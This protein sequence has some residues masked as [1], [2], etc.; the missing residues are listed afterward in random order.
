MAASTHAFA[1][2]LVIFK[3]SRSIEV[4]SVRYENNQCIFTKN[5]SERIVSLDLIEEIYVL[6]K[7]T[8]YPPHQREPAK[9]QETEIINET[10]ETHERNKREKKLEANIA[11]KDT[12]E[13]VEQ[14]YLY[15]SPQGYFQCAIPKSWNHIEMFG[16]HTFSP[17]SLDREAYDKFSVSIIR[18]MEK[19]GI[20][21]LSKEH[22]AK[23]LEALERI[24]EKLLSERERVIDGIET[25]E[26]FVENTRYEP[27]IMHEII[28]IHNGY[29]VSVTLQASPELFDSADRQFEKII[30]SLDFL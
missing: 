8:I 13:P 21:T 12:E 26:K 15:K 18:S 2:T 25:W 14:I 1:Q 17:Y 10:K 5:G 27:K 3:D 20:T 30:E 23:M 16:V 22:R 29:L 6:N 11:S 7:G 4:D 9:T 28:L 24:G 19:A